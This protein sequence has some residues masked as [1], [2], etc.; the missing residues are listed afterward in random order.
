MFFMAS[1]LTSRDGVY[2]FRARVPSHLVSA[3]GR[4]IVSVSLKTKD[5]RPSGSKSSSPGATSRT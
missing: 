3:Y 2:Y 5:A 1:H 4:S